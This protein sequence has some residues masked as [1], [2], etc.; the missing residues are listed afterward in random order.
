MKVGESWKSADLQERSP[1]QRGPRLEITVRVRHVEQLVQLGDA[2]VVR[3]GNLAE[4]GLGHR[5]LREQLFRR[6]GCERLVEQVHSLRGGGEEGGQVDPDLPV[7]T[8]PRGRDG[9][10]ATHQRGLVR[11][12]VVDR[13]RAHRI[14]A[15]LVVQNLLDPQPSQRLAVRLVQPAAV[16]TAQPHRLPV[17]SERP[18][19]DRARQESIELVEPP[20]PLAQRFIAHRRVHHYERPTTDRQRQLIGHVDDLRVLPGPT[21]DGTALPNGGEEAVDA[22]FEHRANAVDLVG[23]TQ[24]GLTETPNRLRTVACVQRGPKKLGQ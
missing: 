18:S 14:G 23:L 24:H 4:I 6:F 9:H 3:A 15:V 22:Q 13:C 7:D 12:H 21:R 20:Q 5:Q 10:P 17:A 2:Q 11:R 8:R 19:E 1:Q 16:D